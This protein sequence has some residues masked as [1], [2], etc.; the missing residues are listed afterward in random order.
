ML[1]TIRRC[2]SEAFWGF[3]SFLFLS[4]LRCSKVCGEGKGGGGG[5]QAGAFAW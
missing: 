3:L 2:K 5:M 4:G 1:E